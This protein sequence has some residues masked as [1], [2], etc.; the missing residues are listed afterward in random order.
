MN[1]DYLSSLFSLQDKVAI[2]TGA[3][4]YFGKEFCETLLLA[5]AKVILYGRGEKL[6]EF[7][8]LLRTKYGGDKVDYCMVDFYNYQSQRQCLQKTMKDNATLD[9][10]VNNAYEFSRETGFNDPSGRIEDISKE[11]WMKCIECGTYW[12]ALS[13]PIVAEKMKHQR[14]GSIINISSM[15]ALIAPDPR[16]YEGTKIMNPPSYGAAKAAILA[17]TR[18]AASFYGEYNIRCNAI[19]P[20]AFPNISGDAYN[21]PRDEDFIKKLADRTVLRRTGLPDDLK[22]A[23]IF[24]ASDASSYV[25]GQMIVVDGGWTVR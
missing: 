15:Y 23:L 17:F 18:Y 5:G 19:V 24:L 10:L 3:A 21:S 14:S 12:Y 1:L 13:T 6:E 4:G 22:G 9:I 7:A 16:L 11:Q 20:G 25:T 8:G 2:I